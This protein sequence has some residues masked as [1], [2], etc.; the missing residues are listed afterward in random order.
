MYS[1]LL[2][3]IVWVISSA[4][5]FEYIL[6]PLVWDQVSG[7]AVSN[8]NAQTSANSYFELI[9]QFLYQSLKQSSKL[10]WHLFGMEFLVKNPNESF[11]KELSISLLNTLP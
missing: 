5:V 9:K 8:R 10:I 7:A 6:P 11:K 1:F 4:S 3:S 2:R